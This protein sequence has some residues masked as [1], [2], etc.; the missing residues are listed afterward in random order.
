MRRQQASCPAR[1]CSAPGQLGM[2]RK[3]L[4]FPFTAIVK[5]KALRAQSLTSTKACRSGQHYRYG[6]WTPAGAGRPDVEAY[7]GRQ[8]KQ[9]YGYAPC[10]LDLFYRGKTSQIHCSS[11]PEHLAGSS[12]HACL[13]RKPPLHDAR[14]DLVGLAHVSSYCSV[15]CFPM[16]ANAPVC[17]RHCFAFSLCEIFL[18]R[19]GKWA[20][21]QNRAGGCIGSLQGEGT[22][23]GAAPQEC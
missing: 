18:S 14:P 11:L 12:C 1:I 16:A 7:V 5:V 4:A 8:G 21:R 6:I 3:L 13:V 10:S 20:P 2:L 17:L 23:A 15:D 9:G 19:S 22:G